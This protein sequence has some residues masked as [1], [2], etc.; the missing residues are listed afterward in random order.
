M[1]LI[2]YLMLLLTNV[3]ALLMVYINDNHPSFECILEISLF[4]LCL[5]GVFREIVAI[6][7]LAA[8]SL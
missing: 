6:L 2:I 5:M 8:S 4:V 3:F 1:F 7:A